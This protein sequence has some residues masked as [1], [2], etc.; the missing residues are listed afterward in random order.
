MLVQEPV[1]P[2]GLVERAVLGMDSIRSGEYDTGRPPQP[3]AW[4]P[5]DDPNKLCKIEQ[6]QFASS[7]GILGLGVVVLG[8]FGVSVRNQTT[9]TTSVD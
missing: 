3:S 1:L 5:G 7:A 9:V 6:P 8:W 2:Q 4:K